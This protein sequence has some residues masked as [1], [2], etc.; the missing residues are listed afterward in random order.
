MF[1]EIGPLTMDPAI[2]TQ[3]SHYSQQNPVIFPNI[4][5]DSCQ[6]PKLNLT[7]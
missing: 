3:V 5:L 1:K 7:K 2:A 6:H 4:F